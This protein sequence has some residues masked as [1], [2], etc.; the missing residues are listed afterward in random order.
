MIEGYEIVTIKLAGG[1]GNVN[2]L[3]YI[4]K[5]IAAVL[6]VVFDGEGVAQFTAEAADR[7]FDRAG[8]GIRRMFPN[9]V[10][11]I[12]DGEKAA[13][14]LSHQK[15]ESKFFGGKQQ[16]IAV[17]VGPVCYDVKP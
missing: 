1:A 9:G 4:T 2:L 16:I 11:Q 15:Q 10:G 14:V 12:P 3:R 17:E 13:F 5:N 8:V 7:S 6:F